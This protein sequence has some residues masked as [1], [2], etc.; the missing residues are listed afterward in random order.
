MSNARKVQVSIPA[1]RYEEVEARWKSYGF[2]SVAEAAR[3][4]LLGDMSEFVNEQRRQISAVEKLEKMSEKRAKTKTALVQSKGKATPA[5]PK[6]GAGSGANY[7]RTNPNIEQTLRY[8]L[9][10]GA[11]TQQS[12]D[13]AR[14]IRK[15][16][17]ETG[18]QK[19]GLY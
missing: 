4:M 19:T 2:T 15:W 11:I 13:N 18:N 1:D 17:D 9:S 16:I 8:W 5:Q 14:G 3:V 10:Q 12:F 7:P 6:V